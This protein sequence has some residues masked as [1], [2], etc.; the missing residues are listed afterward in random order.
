[1]FVER[2]LSLVTTKGLML[3]FQ[4]RLCRSDHTSNHLR[5]GQSC[6]GA[7]LEIIV[8]VAFPVRY[9]DLSIRPATWNSRITAKIHVASAK[10]RHSKFSH[11][12]F[13]R[14]S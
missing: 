1:M 9:Q 3:I 4:G 5:A 6:S 8:A 10:Q 7:N 14:G 12:L 2:S 13:D 11:L